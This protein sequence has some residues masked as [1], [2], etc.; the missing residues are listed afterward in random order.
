MFF[1]G[2]GVMY[3]AGRHRDLARLLGCVTAVS[4]YVGRIRKGHKKDE[5][6]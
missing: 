4:P 3:S 2:S 5:L 1:R 6:G